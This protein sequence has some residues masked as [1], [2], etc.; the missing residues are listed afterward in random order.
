M[1]TIPEAAPRGGVPLHIKVLLG[2]ALG[3]VVGLLVHWQGLQDGLFVVSL[4]E[5]LT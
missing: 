3:A 1:H 4:Q 2:F 5:Y